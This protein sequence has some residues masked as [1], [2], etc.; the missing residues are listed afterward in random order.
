MS[1]LQR[2]ISRPITSITAAAALVA[3]FSVASRFLG[4]IRDHI[5]AGS[6]GADLSM[7]MY[8]AAF[9]VPDFIYN[10]VVLGALSA[11]FIPIFSEMIKKS[12]MHLAT[13]E[14]LVKLASNIFN[15]LL[16]MIIFLSILGIIFADTLTAW[17]APGFS[18]EAKM[19]TAVLTRIMFLS[20]IFLGM[21]GILG[22]ILQSYKR[23]FVY[24]LSPIFYNLGIIFGA[25]VLVRHYGLPGLAWGVVIGA[26]LHF[27]VQLPT[28]WQLGFRYSFYLDLKD[29]SLR[30]IARMMGPRTLSLAVSQIN[31]LAMTAFASTLDSGSLSIFNWANNLQSFPLGV[32]GISFA[33][34]AFPFLSENAYKMEELKIRFSSTIRQILFF[35]IPAS[36][37][38]ITLR[39]QII[40]VVLGSGAFNW[41]DT[42]LTMDTLGFFALSLFA[43][44]S[45]PLLVRMFYARRDSWTPFY[46]GLVSVFVNIG[47][48]YYLRQYFGVAGLALAFSIASIFNFL[49]LWLWLYVKVGSLDIDKIFNSVLKFLAAGIGTG[50]VVQALKFLVWPFIDMQTFA[51]VFI[52]MTVAGTGGLIAYILL[53][54]LFKSEELLAAII[55][56]KRRLPWKKTNLAD[57]GEARGL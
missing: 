54:Y 13:K 7:D 35:I 45:I 2:L 51:G 25:L 4:V 15:A 37:L 1:Y 24:S 16:L 44:A 36:V 6:F 14:T 9:R 29:K 3:S 38:I 20:P 40:R 52:Q 32:F 41:T 22:G 57:Q 49:C 26:F 5:L 56:F 43:Q 11:G 23:F 18:F 53:C 33:V 28:V 21:S 42:V 17:V 27:A 48:A 8:Y 31:L 50:L 30:Q 55:V 10:L 34:A 46:L 19:Q 47:L 39:A 12:E